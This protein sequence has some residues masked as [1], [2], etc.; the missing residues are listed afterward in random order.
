MNELTAESFTVKTTSIP[1]RPGCWN[2]LKVEIFC[3]NKKIGEYQRGYSSFFNTFCPFEQD[4]KWYAL[5]SADYTTTRVMSLPDC[6]D[7]GGEKS[8]SYGFCPV[9][10]YVPRYKNM[11]IKGYTR[12]ELIDQKIPEQNWKWVSEDRNLRIY[13]DDWDGQ[14]D[15]LK[16]QLWIYE[17]YAFISGCVWG[18]DGSWKLQLIDLRKASKGLIVR[19]DLFGYIDLPHG[20]KRLKDCITIHGGTVPVGE[21][22][23][24]A[25]FDIALSKHFRLN[26]ETFERVP[27]DE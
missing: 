7:L 9:D 2:I 26:P 27:F 21:E 13:D 5:Y 16:N 23:T 25:R 11:F 18:D 8:D 6:K 1:S 17:N 15:K 4:G 24:C 10:Y 19:K 14:S 22:E 20:H 12:Q 3:F